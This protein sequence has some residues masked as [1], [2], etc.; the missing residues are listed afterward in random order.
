MKVCSAILTLITETLVRSRRQQQPDFYQETVEKVKSIMET[1]IYGAINIPSIANQIG[2]SA[3]RLNEIFK[4][5]TS[6][7]PYQYFIQLKIHKAEELLSE[8]NISVKEAAWRMGFEDQHYFSRLFK[9]K[10][11]IAPSNWKK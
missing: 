5:F 3:S 10:T 9:H 4:Q 1:N 2:I 8:E 7:T 6:M 11:G